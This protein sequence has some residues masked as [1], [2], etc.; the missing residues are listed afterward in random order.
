MP[1]SPLVKIDSLYAKVENTQIGN[2]VKL[3][4]QALVDKYVDYYK[5][6]EDYFTEESKVVQGKS[7]ITSIENINYKAPSENTLF[8]FETLLTSLSTIF[9][10]YP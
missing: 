9:S 5:G 1:K 4:L 7:Q 3:L 8:G 10:T 6:I 2:V